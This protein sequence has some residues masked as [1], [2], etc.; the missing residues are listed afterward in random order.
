MNCSG[1][2][3]KSLGRGFASERFPAIAC[4]AGRRVDDP[5]LESN[6]APH[7]AAAQASEISVLIMLPRVRQLERGRRR[8]GN[9]F[10]LDV[11]RNLPEWAGEYRL[12]D[13]VESH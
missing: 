2:L 13:D 6:A 7:R 3:P 4:S 12:H 9:G 5:R 8:V 11:Y 10:L 1:R